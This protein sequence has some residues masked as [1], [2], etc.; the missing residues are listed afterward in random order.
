[1]RNKGN[2]KRWTLIGVGAAGVLVVGGLVVY[3]YGREGATPAPLAVSASP[4][5]VTG[6]ATSA[7]GT[8]QVSRGSQAGYRVKEVLFGQNT[9]AVGR[10][11]KISGQLTVAGTT[12]TRAGFTVDLASVASDQN[13]RDEQFRGRIME[14]SRYPNAAFTLTAP[15]DLHAVPTVGAELTAKAT[16]ELTIKGTTNQVTFAVRA[17]RTGNDTFA[18]SGSIPVRFADYKIANPGFGPI[19]T[20]DDGTIEFLLTLA[21]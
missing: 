15:V 10:T 8:W 4:S 12:V 2:W 7:D 5:A 3:I 21:H 6:I 19:Q 13:R 16:G 20:E 14:T 11:S 18:V 9:E 1:M 17:T